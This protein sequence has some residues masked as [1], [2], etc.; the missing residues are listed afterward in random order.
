MGVPVWVRPRLVGLVAVGGALGTGVREVVGLRL[1]SGVAWPWSLLFVNVTGAF[2]LALLTALLAGRGAETPRR[3]DVRLAVGTGAFGA[4]T[5]YGS[6]AAQLDLMVRAG[7]PGPALAFALL[8][9]AGGLFAGAVG[10]ALA[11][12]GRSV[13]ASCARPDHGEPL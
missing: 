8:S 12:S 9:L 3:R 2:G 13:P 4:Y 7:R 11:R 6:L 10:F 5:T 1:P